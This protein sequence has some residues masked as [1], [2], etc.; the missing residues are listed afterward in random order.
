[1]PEGGRGRRLSHSKAQP[2]VP[3]STTDV[4]DRGRT[5]LQ[6]TLHEVAVFLHPEESR[7]EGAGHSPS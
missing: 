2:W 3:N 4:T 5:I 7:L 6:I 1:M